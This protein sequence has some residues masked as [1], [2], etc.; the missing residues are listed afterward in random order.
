MT[1][2]KRN[3]D[4]PKCVLVT[5]FPI[6]VARRLVRELVCGGDRVIVLHREKFKT[7]ADAFVADVNENDGL[8]GGEALVMQGDIL[9]LDLGLSGKEVRHLH[10]EVEEVHHLAAVQYLGISSDKMR[11]VN[12]EGL[13]EVLELALGMKRLQRICHWS[14]AFVAGGR[15]GVA[16]EDELMVGQTF[17]NGYER[18][19]AEAEDLARSVM[20][21][22]PITVV[23]PS[24]IVGDSETGEVQRFDGPYLLINAIINAPAHTP[25][26]LPGQGRLP[27]NVVPA[28]F[29]VK[30][31][32]YLTRHPA[33]VGRT[34]HLVDPAPLTAHQFYNAVADAAGRPRPTLFL[35]NNVARLI[36]SAPGLR[37]LVPHERT[38]LEWFD[39]ALRFDDSAAHELLEEGGIHCPQVPSYV[40]VLVRYVREYTR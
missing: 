8:Q 14:T 13:R 35:P 5:G 2:P 3:P 23:R 15:D 28:D 12:V 7:E 27:L 30:A 10:G 33:A 4:G 29:V 34:F 38:F 24:V 20:D 22:L 21:K 19:K 16:L 6:Y 18:S 11:R 37:R 26:P 9:E 36:L 25:V 1:D 39:S 40:D 32:A 17:R 31:A